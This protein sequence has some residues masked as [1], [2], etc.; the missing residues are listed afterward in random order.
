[1]QSIYQSFKESKVWC[2]WRGGGGAVV[3]NDLCCSSEDA[4]TELE[5]AQQGDKNGSVEVL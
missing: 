1:M 4:L 5:L 3:T 2:W